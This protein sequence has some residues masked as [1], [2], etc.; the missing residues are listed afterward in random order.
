MLNHYRHRVCSNYASYY[1]NKGESSYFGL[2]EQ[3]V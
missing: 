3:V 1:G 2:E